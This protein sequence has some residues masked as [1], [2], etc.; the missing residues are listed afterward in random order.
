MVRH[1]EGDSQGFD[2]FRGYQDRTPAF[3]ASGPSLPTR[4]DG[5]TA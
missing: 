4:M 1:G 5:K 2:G 3:S